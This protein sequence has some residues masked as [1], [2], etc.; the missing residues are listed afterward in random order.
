MAQKNPLLDFSTVVDIERDYVL[1]DGEKYFIRS[2]QEMSLRDYARLR[3]MGKRVVKLYQTEE[4]D[5]EQ[6]QGLIDTLEELLNLVF[7]DIKQETLNKLSD[8]QQMEIIQAFT[9]LLTTGMSK[10]AIKKAEK[11][12]MKEIEA[13][14]K[15]TAAQA[16]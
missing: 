2:K 9:K 4:A 5:T 11:E 14:K 6:L 13:E 3:I 8:L 10:G 1:I 7:V 12:L 16:S 15:T